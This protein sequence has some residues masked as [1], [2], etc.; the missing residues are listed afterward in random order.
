MIHD[1]YEKLTPMEKEFVDE[2][3]QSMFPFARAYRIPLAGDDRAEKMAEALAVWV[4]ES[5]E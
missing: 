2:M 3:M 5:R 1:K 4:T